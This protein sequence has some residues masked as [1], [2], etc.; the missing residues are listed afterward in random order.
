MLVVAERFLVF[1]E[2]E[3]LLGK[4]GAGRDGIGDF[5]LVG[6]RPVAF[7]RIERRDNA[8]PR[9]LPLHAAEPFRHELDQH[10]GERAE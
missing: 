3:A 8:A 5:Q 7:A 6:E 10:I 2:R 9:L 4:L 1:P